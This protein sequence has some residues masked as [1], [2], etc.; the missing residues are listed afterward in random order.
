MKSV[1]ALFLALSFA[2]AAS[3]AGAPPAFKP[4]LAR[5]QA[6]AVVCQACHTSDGTRGLPANPILQGQHPEYLVKQ[7]TEFKAGKRQ[8][9]IM[10][11]FAATLSEDDM[12]HVAAYYASKPAPTGFATKADTVLLGERIYRGGIAERKVPACAGCHTPNGAGIPSQYPRL[13]GQHAGYTEAQLLGF[14]SGARANS[15]QM[16]TIA[17]KMKDHEIK[18]VS[19]YLAGLR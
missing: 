17:D 4:D 11:G 15:T 7:L 6:V 13:G 16:T 9:A 12:K 1:L 14:R 5:G 2:G 19:D 3:A 18:A 8:N 10:Q